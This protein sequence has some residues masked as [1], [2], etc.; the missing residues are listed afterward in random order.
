[1]RVLLAV[2]ILVVAAEAADTFWFGGRYSRALWQD[3]SE[4]TQQVR[5]LSLNHVLPTPNLSHY[6]K[7]P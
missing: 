6:W 1:M 7:V 3:V 4:S 2:M 5:S